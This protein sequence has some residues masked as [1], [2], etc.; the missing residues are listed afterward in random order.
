MNGFHEKVADKGNKPRCGR[1]CRSCLL[2]A[3]TVMNYD[4]LLN[5]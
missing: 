4:S 3:A 2:G 5:S 1:L